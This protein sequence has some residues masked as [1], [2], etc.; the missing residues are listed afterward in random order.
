MPGTDDGESTDDESTSADVFGLVGNEVRAEI[1]RTFGDARVEQRYPPVLTFSELR[2]RTDTGIDS[3]RFNYHLQQLVGHYVE[4]V[5]DG[6]RMRSPGRT[7]YQTIRAG[8]FSGPESA[9]IGDA[10]FECY[11]CGATVEASIEDGDIVVRCPDCEYTYAI[12]GAPP[13]AIEDGS[14]DVDQVAAAYHHRHLA[15]ARGVCVTCGNEPDAE[16]V[17]PGTLPFADPERQELYVYRS[18]RNCGDQRHLSLGT[19][20][21]PDPDVVGFCRDHGV[22][23]LSTPLWELEFAAT[24]RSVTVR[25]TD[26][27]EAALEIA[28]GDDRLEL[29][30]D[31]DLAIVERNRR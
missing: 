15:F 26:P 17:R 4:R 3:S 18:C 13:G 9:R 19:A 16:L 27:W 8:T 31:G 14:V 22:D 5:E 30:V 7:L 24:D 23:V 1:I 2:S 10:G 12:A 29:V 6:Y 25:S 11:Y 28:Y 21:L 20:L